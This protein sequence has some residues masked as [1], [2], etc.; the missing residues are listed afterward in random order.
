M[1][2]EITQLIKIYLWK[3]KPIIQT[4]KTNFKNQILNR[5]S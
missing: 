5:N 1:H 4:I 3:I 2:S